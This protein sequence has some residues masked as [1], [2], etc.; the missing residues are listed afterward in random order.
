MRDVSF[1]P[2]HYRPFDILTLNGD[3]LTGLPLIERKEILFSEFPDL[4]TPTLIENINEAMTTAKAHM[5]NGYEGIVLKN[6]EERYKTGP[7]AWVKVKTKDENVYEV[8]LIDPAQERIEFIVPLPN[9]K[10]RSVSAKCLNRDKA[11]LKL[12]DLVKIEH[13]GVLA[14]GGLRHPVYKGKA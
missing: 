5:H 1:Q 14:L 3:D 7:C 6:I 8:I 13:Q 9:G 11:T 2:L 12:G 10:S 4:P